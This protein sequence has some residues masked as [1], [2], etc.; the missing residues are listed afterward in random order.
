MGA[1]ESYLEVIRP[2]FVQNVGRFREAIDYLGNYRGSRTLF[3]MLMLMHLKIFLYLG[4][5]AD[6]HPK[7]VEHVMVNIVGGYKFKYNIH[8]GTFQKLKDER[9]RKRRREDALRF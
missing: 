8:R 5:T 4:T 9:R 1:Y 7:I 6:D 2:Y 3:T